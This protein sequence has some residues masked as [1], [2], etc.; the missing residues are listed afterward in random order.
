MT[1][2]RLTRTPLLVTGLLSLLLAATTDA[3]HARPS[4]DIEL[5]PVGEYRTGIFDDGAAEIS[6]F[7]PLTKRLFVVNGSTNAVDVLD[8]ADPSQPAY[9]FS[10]DLSPYG[11]GPT[12]VDVSLGRVAVSVESGQAPGKVAF[13]RTVG[14]CD[15]VIAV[16]VGALPDM[17][18]F[19]PNGRWMLTANEAEPSDDYGVDPAGSVSVIDLRSGLAHATVATADFTAFDGHED[20]LRAQGIR[21]FGPGAS[22][23]QDL[24]PEYIAVSHNSRTA[25]VVMQEANAIAEVDI[26]DARVTDIWALGSKDHSLPGN[27]LDPSNRDSG[28][29]IANWPVHG[30]YLPDGLAAFRSRGHSYL[31][32]GN[33]GDS[34]DYGGY[35]EE[36]RVADVVL[37]PTAFPNAAALQDNA[38][39][40]RLK[41]TTANGDDDGDGDFDRLF[42]YGARS[43]SIWSTDGEQVFDSGDDFE[44]ITATL[45][46]AD[47]NSD[48]TENDS[49]DSRSD[50]KGPEPEGVAIG[51]IRG[52]SYAFI[53]LERMGGVFVYDITRPAE[54]EFVSYVTTRIFSGDPEADTAGDL[55]PEGLRFIPAWQSPTHEP[56]LVCANE[57]SG[58]VNVYAISVDDHHGGHHG[59]HHG[60]DHLANRPGGVSLGQNSPNPFNPKT[61]IH[62]SLPDAGRVQLAVFDVQG[63]RI[64]QLVD[65]VQSSGEHSV[66]FDGRGLASGVYYYRLSTEQGSTTR[67]MTLLK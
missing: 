12:H 63:R 2:V 15:F 36:A 40:G 35:S 38:A 64:A 42:S 19:S 14:D 41:I 17:V 22:A 4:L 46:P 13:F 18:V 7:C 43:F 8:F 5:T 25:W 32:T 67:R 48:N 65:D 59:G 60:D 31:V 57:V 53:G 3:L 9:L 37:D 58:S 55:G 21:I 61:T 66:D 16:E 50:D 30:F 52:R 28:I 33:E 29:E 1:A 45:Q 24:E 54:A 27:G 6:A 39:L 56:L 34:R 26:H 49:F 10:L 44:Q 20:E 23:S 51:E 47:F 11:D 62:Y